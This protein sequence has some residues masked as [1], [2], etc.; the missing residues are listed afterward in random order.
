LFIGLFLCLVGIGGGGVAVVQR[1]WYLVGASVTGLWMG[2]VAM[3]LAKIWDCL[4]QLL[5]K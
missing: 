2:V 1:D 5:R 4:E 3:V